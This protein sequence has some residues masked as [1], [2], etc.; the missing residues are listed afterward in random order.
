MASST[1]SAAAAAAAVPSPGGGGG[2]PSSTSTSSRRKEL[3]RAL[4]SAFAFSNID[5]NAAAA[6]AAASSSSLFEGYAPP[7]SLLDLIDDY[8]GSSDV[9]RS[10]HHPPPAA[11]AST[12]S[13]SV[14]AGS[15]SAHG[16]QTGGAGGVPTGSGSASGPGSGSATTT[17]TAAAVQAGTTSGGAAGPTASAAGGGGGGLGSG[18][19]GR[20][21]DVRRIQDALLEDCFNE[22][23][24]ALAALA[25]RT[26]SSP[27]IAALHA[28]AR[29]ALI[30]VLD[31]FA[32]MDS[33]VVS[34]LEVRYIWWERL[35]QPALLHSPGATASSSGHASAGHAH[36][37]GK[38]ASADDAKARLAVST[39]DF[40]ALGRGASRAARELVLR[41]LCHDPEERDNTKWRNELLSVCFDSE[42]DSLAH[43]NLQE[44]LTGFYK[45]HPK[46]ERC[47]AR[48]PIG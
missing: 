17:T 5:D 10:Q 19:T 40:I 31:K 36:E 4:R 25:S 21:K 9:Q 28:R 41:A 46:V 2:G 14:P 8:A 47:S 12:A 26:N 6:A 22:G 37:K 18:L 30:L 39:A 13:A 34:P 11:A 38:R 3:T 42:P 43:R 48:T 27:D 29:S 23:I 45:A 16:S 33:D 32:S 1:S 24:L 35:L 44:V 7:E 15:S 20:E